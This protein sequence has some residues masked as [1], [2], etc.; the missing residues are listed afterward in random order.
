MAPGFRMIALSTVFLCIGRLTDLL[1]NLT[2][3]LNSGSMT[4]L[5]DVSGT[6]FAILNAYGFYQIYKVWKIGKK[7]SVVTP[8]IDAQSH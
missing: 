7:E 8:Q 5:G 2:P 1:T 4:N 3:I 6:I